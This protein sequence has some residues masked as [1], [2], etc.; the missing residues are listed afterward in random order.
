M[1]LPA[2]SVSQS[3]YRITASIPGRVL[4]GAI[5]NQFGWWL[6]T[7]RKRQPL[8]WTACDTRRDAAVAVYEHAARRLNGN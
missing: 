6:P 2:I 4:A 7:S 5:R 8:T 3:Q 1:T